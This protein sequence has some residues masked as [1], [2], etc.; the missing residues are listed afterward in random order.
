MRHCERPQSLS[1]PT[2]KG[3]RNEHEETINHDFYHCIFIIGSAFCAFASE[4]DSS[5]QAQQTEEAA[6]DQDQQETEAAE[7]VEEPASQMVSLGVFKTT[8]YCPCRSCSAGWGR[9]TCTGAVASSQHTIAV[10]PR[11]IP[12]G[13]RVMINGVVY[14]AEDKGGGVKGHHIDIFYDTHAE[15]KNHG[16]QN[17]EVFLLS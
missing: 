9:N 4:N 10:D 6:N 5:E 15:S 3:G 12:Y 14:I 16:I 17:V 13:T 1:F 8:G 7:N 2:A 11:V